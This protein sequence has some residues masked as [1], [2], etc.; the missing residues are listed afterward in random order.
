MSLMYILIIIYIKNKECAHCGLYPHFI[1]LTGPVS[2]PISLNFIILFT[3]N[4]T[5]IVPN[6]DSKV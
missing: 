6:W 3:G 1:L 2:V 4:T 5:E